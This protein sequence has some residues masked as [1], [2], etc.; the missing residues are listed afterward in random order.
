MCVLEHNTLRRHHA[1]LLTTSH[2][3]LHPTSHERTRTR[4]RTHTSRWL[5]LPVTPEAIVNAYKN[6][7][8]FSS[9]GKEYVLQALSRSS[10]ISAVL[11][12]SDESYWVDAHVTLY[13]SGKEGEYSITGSGEVT[14]ASWSAPLWAGLANWLDDGTKK[15]LLSS[16]EASGLWQEGGVLT[17]L[18][19]SGQ[20]WDS[21]NAWAP[22]QHMMVEGLERLATTQSLAAAQKLASQWI[23]SNLIGYDESGLMYEKYDGK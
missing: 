6:D 5:K 11:W 9:E 1:S 17:T 21:P 20:Q 22:L 13:E 2:L 18:V 8:F 23:D 4:T 15:S 16:L 12:D 10:G 3:T 19:E 7:R 14:A